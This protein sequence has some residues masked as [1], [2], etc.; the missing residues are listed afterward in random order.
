[1]KAQLVL[2]A[3]HV[4]QGALTEAQ[5]VLDSLDS[6]RRLS[7]FTVLVEEAE[8]VLRGAESAKEPQLISTENMP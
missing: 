5:E 2:I 6:Y 4:E 3:S 1:M 8:A 7:N